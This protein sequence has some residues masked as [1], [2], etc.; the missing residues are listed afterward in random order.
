[1][2]ALSHTRKG[3]DGYGRRLWKMEEWGV[4]TFVGWCHILSVPSPADTTQT[5][6]LSPVPPPP[7]QPDIFGS[8]MLCSP[9]PAISRLTVVFWMCQSQQTQLEPAVTHQP[10]TKA[11]LSASPS[12]PLEGSSA[13][14]REISDIR[15][16]M[17]PGFRW[18]G[19]SPPAVLR[20]PSA[21]SSH[22][23]QRL[24]QILIPGDSASL[25]LIPRIRRKCKSAECR[26]CYP[27]LGT[28]PLHS[29]A[30]LALS[31]HRG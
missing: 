17:Q 25:G 12:S 7:L 22:K 21:A 18:I 13:I 2:K 30:A 3:E 6:S 28:A 19:S 15:V 29:T 8:G 20:L 1:M 26:G 24:Y 31:A 27:S 9:F 14:R 16:L 4:S 10:G 5:C 11:T 23:E